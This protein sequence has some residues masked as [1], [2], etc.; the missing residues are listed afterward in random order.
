MR[1]QKLEKFGT[2]YMHKGRYVQPYKRG[3]DMLLLENGSNEV[4]YTQTL[5][6]PYKDMEITQNVLSQKQN[7]ELRRYEL[8]KEFMS[9]MMNNS[10]YLTTP[11][12]C[13]SHSKRGRK[14]VHCYCE[15]K[16]TSS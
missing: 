2:S 15:I 3:D 14:S 5:N 6:Q 12:M 7:D 8:A 4:I 11:G 1:F 9:I 10:I 16:C 13:C